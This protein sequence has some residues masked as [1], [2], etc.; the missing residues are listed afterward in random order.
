MVEGCGLVNK[1][2]G[3]VNNSAFRV[4]QRVNRLAGRKVI[5]PSRLASRK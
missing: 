5:V 3:P 4:A 2:I 1:S